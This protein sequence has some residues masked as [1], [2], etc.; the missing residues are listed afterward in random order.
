MERRHVASAVLALCCCS[1]LAAV[2]C[3]EGN[4]GLANMLSGYRA[5]ERAAT[6]TR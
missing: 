4:R 1:G 6:R 3:H 2:A 5:Q